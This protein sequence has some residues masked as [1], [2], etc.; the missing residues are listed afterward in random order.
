MS[1]LK[2]SLKER[3]QEM[4]APQ[5]P[6][7]EDRE[8]GN[9]DDLT[10]VILTIRDYGF[11]NG[12]NGEYAVFIVDEEPKEFFFG[13]KVLTEALQ[14]FDADGYHQTI[15]DEG[16]PVVLTKKKTKDGKKNYTAVLFYPEEK[17]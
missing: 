16:L 3:A 9:S 7:M 12:D 5:L 1:N 8:K 11:L 13:G 4:S 6:I 17:K 15:N 10:G 2:K 14:E